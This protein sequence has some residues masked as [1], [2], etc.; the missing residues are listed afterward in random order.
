MVMHW[1]NV[2]PVFIIGCYRSGTSLLRLML[3]AHQH[4]WIS[5]EGAYIYH[6]RSKLTANDDLSNSKNL[7]ALHRAILPFLE[8]EKWLTLPTFEELLEWVKQYGTHTRSLIIFYNTWDARALG[9]QKLLW[10]GD[11]A[12]YH[13]HNVPYF[14]SL[15]PDSK[16]IFMIRD[17]RDIHTSIKFNYKERYPLDDIMNVWERALLDGLLAEQFLGR[18]RVK[19]VRYE[20]LV[21]DPKNQLKEICTFLGVVFEEEMLAYYKSE[22]AKALSRI[23]HHSNVV[24]AVFANSV[25]KYREMLTE[26]EIYKI[27][28]RLTLPMRCLGYLSADE[29]NELI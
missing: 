9:K 2:P 12:N 19:Q 21:T 8:E 26:E 29:Y 16:Y 28:K 5:C 22:A 10:W 20:S 13:V 11:N 23:N 15:F 3:S 24:K 18:H 14:S 4:I 25:G 6:I 1:I 7:E 17:P 27:N